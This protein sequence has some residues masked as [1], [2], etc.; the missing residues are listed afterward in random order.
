MSFRSYLLLLCYCIHT[1]YSAVCTSGDCI[2][3]CGSDDCSEVIC[4]NSA[5]SCV[6]DCGS[7]NCA[8]STMYLAARL[9]NEVVCN[10][11]DSCKS[12]TL[13]CGIPDDI[14][15]GYSLS[16]FDGPIDECLFSLSG[17]AI[18]DN[19]KIKCYHQINRCTVEA[20]TDNDDF[21]VSTFECDLTSQNSE[22]SMVCFSDKACGSDTSDF[23]CTASHCLCTG[24]G[25]D[26]LQQFVSNTPPPSDIST[27]P[28][29]VPSFVP[30]Y[31]PSAME[32]NNPSVMPSMLPSAMPSTLQPITVT[33]TTLQPVT[34]T[35]TASMPITISPTTITQT[36]VMP[37]RVS[38][39]T[40]SPTTR[41]THH[42]INS[43]TMNPQFTSET[44][45]ETTSTYTT[46]TTAETIQT[47]ISETPSDT[48]SQSVISTLDVVDSAE[49]FETTSLSVSVTH[50]L[51]SIELDDCDSSDSGECVVIEEMMNSYV[52]SALD[53]YADVYVIDTDIDDD[54]VTLQVSIVSNAE[55]IL[56]PNIME[57][58]IENELYPFYGDTHVTVQVIR[59]NH[60]RADASSPAFSVILSGTL[61][62]ITCGVGF[63]SFVI[64]AFAGCKCGVWIYKKR[65]Q[66]IF[67]VESL[68]DVVEIG[69]IGDIK[70]DSGEE[71]P[72]TNL[73]YDA[74]SAIAR[75]EKKDDVN[76][77]IDQVNEPMAQEEGNINCD[78]EKESKSD[79]S[80]GN[81]GNTSTKTSGN[82]EFVSSGS[83]DVNTP[84]PESNSKDSNHKMASSGESS[85]FNSESLFRAN[86]LRGTAGEEILTE[87]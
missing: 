81:E 8:S 53:M 51:I 69:S 15:N 86:W 9:K 65:A 72:N 78:D 71:I 10:G 84:L 4:T 19:G 64:C 52:V 24:D 40:L 31:T 50:L 37:T 27:M 21:K 58:Q 20:Q 17:N 28:S 23:I 26:G 11:G 83:S 1:N 7:T 13:Y 85:T 25:C 32:S 60:H 73:I 79:E 3:D 57:N 34:I 80:T 45:P 49:V 56:E 44:P 67:I 82:I 35:P 47:T 42:L 61:L 2:F 66:Q 75:A 29:T 43:S 38:P 55:Q 18:P 41:G 14:P 39:I 6:I 87:E 12:S 33:P 5:S 22:C 16:Q 77:D 36:T 46:V 76:I 74:K 59:S 63:I 68:E 54:T 62:W 70:N 30:T 48:T